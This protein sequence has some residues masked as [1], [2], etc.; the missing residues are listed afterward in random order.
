MDR[1]AP[2]GDRIKPRRPRVRWFAELVPLLMVL[3]SLAG[4]LLLIVGAHRKP[5]PPPIAAHRVVDRAATVV[6]ALPVPPPAAI[7]P[8]P[9]PPPPP[10]PAE[11]PTPKE[12]ARLQAL[13]TVDREAVARADRAVEA[14]ERAKARTSGIVEN[15]DRQEKAIRAR[16]V[17][18]EDHALTMEA[19]AE[20]LEIDRQILN[21]NRDE[22]RASLDRSRLRSRTAHSIQPFKGPNGTWRRPIAI[23]CTE[24]QVRIQP[25]GP[26]FGLM[27]LSPM[28]G[29][30]G[31]PFLAAVAQE[32]MNAQ[33]GP[34][35]DG[36]PSVP[37]I[38]FIVRPNG[39]RPYYEALA[40]LEPMGL[41]FG[42]ELVGQDWEITYPDPSETKDWDTS[43]PAP[44]RW[45]T[46]RPLAGGPDRGP[47]PPR[48][49]DEV[50]AFAH[51][52]GAYA[53]D[54]DGKPVL[55]PGGL[56]GAGGIGSGPGVFRGGGIGNGGGG[57]GG[58]GGFAVGGGAPGG[59]GLS[60]EPATRGGFDASSPSWQGGGRGNGFDSGPRSVT[61]RFRPPAGN[62]LAN[63]RF[64]DNGVGEGGG[65]STSAGSG[66]KPSGTAT[67]SGG[68]TEALGTD[69]ATLGQPGSVETATTGGA[70]TGSSPTTGD[71]GSAAHGEAAG[72]GS[73]GSPGSGGSGGTGKGSGSGP[74][75][76]FQINYGTRDF[77]ST[78]SPSSSPPP[79]S[80][81]RPGG[82]P[83][84]G[85]TSPP[86]PSTAKPKG[87]GNAEEPRIETGL[88]LVVVCEPRGVIIH[89]G[90][91]R[92]SQAAIKGKDAS[93]VKALRTIVDA[94]Q[95]A[96]P[97]LKWKPRI[98]FL[99]E[100]G[101]HRTMWAARGELFAEGVDWPLTVQTAPGITL[102]TPIPEVR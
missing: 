19:E 45:P 22:A 72:A 9:P 85:A 66:N 65:G 59:G 28:L 5:I 101:G 89:P 95:L 57:G 71:A 92:L 15:L 102:R 1:S 2:K 49:L 8:P 99:V 82:T 91:Y 98:R 97:Q 13:A 34:T 35:P 55:F 47:D 7:E 73:G 69:F 84:A 53:T 75:N 20:N 62:S 90:A 80:R 67:A 23:E 81:S 68:G 60:T 93:L 6:H 41:A 58:G 79:P 64:A 88:E 26:S 31:N 50:E 51:Q 76:E 54:S 52:G 44:E 94:R 24:G 10:P 38:L 83:A 70:E 61:D 29:I 63:R 16:A 43:E 37:Y 100:P 87:P 3:G 48:S 32:T 42:Y 12:V 86:K 78:P 18:L 21:K 30:R 40:K 46:S 25:D 74:T 36:A 11:D 96:E 4:V 77:P 27:E 33:R 39:I 17:A 56:G 14:L